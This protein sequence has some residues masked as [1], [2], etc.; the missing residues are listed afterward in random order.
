MTNN[1]NDS[2]NDKILIITIITVIIILIITGE[3]D[4]VTTA[5][6]KFTSNFAYNDD[7]VI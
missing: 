6:L 3:T 4:T 2:N 5:N 1:N 7:E